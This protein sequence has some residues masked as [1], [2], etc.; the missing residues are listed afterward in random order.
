MDLHQWLAKKRIQKKVFAAT[1][2]IHRNQVMRACKGTGIGKILAERIE[3][4]TDGEVSR[5]SVRPQQ[6][7]VKPKP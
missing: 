2:G 7:K 3:K 4:I 6:K 5:Y 1:L